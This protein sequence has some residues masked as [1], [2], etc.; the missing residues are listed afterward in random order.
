ML[1]RFHTWDPLGRGL[2]RLRERP[3]RSPGANAA[4]VLFHLARHGIPGPAL[5]AFGQRD[6][7]RARADSFVLTPADSAAVPLNA[8]LSGAGLTRAARAAILTDCGRLLGKL[9]G[10]GLRLDPGRV[11]RPIFGL[12]DGG[13]RVLSAIGLRRLRRFPDGR[14]VTELR[15]LF[16]CELPGLSRPDRARVLRGYLGER[17]ADRTARRRFLAGIR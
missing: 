9:N 10:A 3:W 2:A 6:T 12:A 14:R 5:L 4:R 11:N 17:W 8:A 1:T 15:R 7:G 16:R 13:L